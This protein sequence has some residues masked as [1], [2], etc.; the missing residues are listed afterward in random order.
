MSLLNTTWNVSG[1]I[2]LFYFVYIFTVLPFYSL[3][4]WDWAI[5]KAIQ[6]TYFETNCRGK[7]I[8]FIV[9]WRIWLIRKFEFFFLVVFAFLIYFRI[10][11]RMNNNEG[12][13]YRVNFNENQILCLI[14]CR[15]LLVKS[16]LIKYQWVKWLKCYNEMPWW[17]GRVLV[18][19]CWKVYYSSY[20]DFRKS[21][22]FSAATLISMTGSIEEFVS[23]QNN[24]APLLVKLFWTETPSIHR[25]LG[26][27]KP[28]RSPRSERSSVSVHW[29]ELNLC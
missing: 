1:S 3:Y 11:I 6:L 12:I 10:K 23:K 14:A 24:L 2:H 21:T 8:T 29:M 4:S 26:H 13:V 17:T 15:W 19:N 7:I 16:V 28:R 9:L 5:S 20:Y 22:Y 25:I 18:G 27:P